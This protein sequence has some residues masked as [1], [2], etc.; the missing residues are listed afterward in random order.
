M[1]T[2]T[3]E[4]N[5]NALNKWQIELDYCLMNLYTTQRGTINMTKSISI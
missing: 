2:D 4:F 1:S 5:D 3:N